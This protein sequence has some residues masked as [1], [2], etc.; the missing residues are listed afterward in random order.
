MRDEK[1]R[2]SPIKKDC[3]FVGQEDQQTTERRP[4]NNR[5]KTNKQAREDQQTTEKPMWLFLQ[6]FQA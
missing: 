6:R 2:V 4:T 1:C 5:E 3:A